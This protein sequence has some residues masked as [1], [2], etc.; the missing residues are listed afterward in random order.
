MKQ[1]YYFN[2][3]DKYNEILKTINSFILFYICTIL[4]ALYL[5]INFNKTI[6]NI[7]RGLNMGLLVINI[8]FFSKN[9]VFSN[10]QMEKNIENTIQILISF[11][12]LLNV[13]LVII[14]LI[15]SDQTSIKIFSILY[16]IAIIIFVILKK[17]ITNYINQ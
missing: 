10:L 1:K 3:K 15:V 16:I 9:S 12:L 6:F 14:D 2:N 17:T 4:V 11:A 13:F 5:Y 8:Q 7:I